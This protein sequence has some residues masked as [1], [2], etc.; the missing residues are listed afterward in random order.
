MRKFLTVIATLLLTV[1]V[2]FADGPFRNHRYDA[3]KVL[4]VTSDDIVFIGNSI[5]NM[6]EWWEAFGN[7]NVKN[8]GVS[9]AVTQEALD[10]IEAI[11]AGNPKKAFIMLGTNDLGTAG[12]NNAEHV[13]RNV[14]LI[15]ERFR[16][17]S[18]DTKLYIQS[19]LPSGLRDMTLQQ[20]T[21]EALSALCDGTDVIYIDLWTML[22]GIE[23][24]ANGLSYDKLHLTA[25]A[26]KIWCDAIAPYVMDNDE[27]A[28]VYPAD[29]ANLQQN[30]G[31]STSY[32]MRA[33]VFSLLPV[34]NDD[35]LMVGD[36]MIHGGEWHELLQ[37]AK[38]KSRGT[39]WGYPGPSLAQMLSY[40]PT[41]LHDDD[42]PAQVFLYT[43]V[44]DVNGSTE[45]ATV[46]ENYK[47]IV[48][49]ILE[50]SPNTK[51]TMMSLQPTSTASTNTGRVKPFNDML[52]EYA[53]EDNAD[54]IEY[55]D[56]YSDF[57]TSENVANTD[58]FTGNYLYGKGYVKVAQSVAAAINEDG[59]VA[60]TDEKAD[61]LYTRF[62]NRTALGQAITTAA[63][64]PEGDGVGQ[65]TTA[66]L[67]DVK[68]AISS[69]YSALKSSTTA[70]ES[71]TD[72]IS[73]LTTAT[74]N[75]RP[76]I[77]L[78][79]ASTTDATVWYQLYTPNRN[80]KYLS[81]NGVGEGVTGEDANNY[82]ATMWKFVERDDNTF[83]IINRK[84]GSYLNPVANYD[85]QVYTSEAKPDAGWTFEY[86]NTPGLFIVHCGTVQLNQTTK[87]GTPVYNW[88]AGQTGTDRSDTGCQ[89]KIL[90]V[91]GEPDVEPVVPTDE[92]FNNVVKKI[93]NLTEGWYQMRVLSG[94]ATVEGYVSAGTNNVLNANEEYRQSASNYYSLKLAAYDSSKPATAWVYIKPIGSKYLVKSINGHAVLENCTSSRDI[95]QGYTT[96]SMS[97]GGF[98]SVDKWCYW[99][100]G[101][102]EAPFIGKV[103]SS[104]NK[105]AFSRVAD[106]ELSAY[107]IYTVVIDGIE[108]AT[109]IGNDPS[110][111]YT[112]SAA[113]GGISKVYNNGNFFFPA[114]TVPV[115][116]DFTI[117]EGNYELTV[118]AT[119]KTLTV[120]T[121]VA[122]DP[123]Y[124]TLNFAFTRGT[125][126][127]NSVVTVTDANGLTLTDVTATIVAT[128]A[129]N[130]WLSGTD[131]DSNTDILCVNT[132]SNAATSAY[133]ITYTLSISGLPEGWS[134]DKALFNHRA[135][136]KKGVFQS[137]SETTTDFHCNF[138]LQSG[139]TGDALESFASLTD[140]SIMVPSPNV[141]TL[142][143]ANESAAESV[144]GNL[145]VKLT[146]YMGTTNN[147]CFYGLNGITLQMPEEEEVEVPVDYIVSPSTGV[148]YRDG[149]TTGQ[150]W[151]NKWV[152]TTSTE[153]PVELTLVSNAN[154]MT[155]SNG[156]LQLAGG[157]SGTATY[158]L[159]VPTGYMITGY[160]FD[161]VRAGSSDMTITIGDNNY[162]ATTT[163]ANV[164]ITNL[165]T[166]ST[167]FV[168]SGGNNTVN[169]SNF[170]V[171]IEKDNYGTEIALGVTAAGIGATDVSLLRFN[172]TIDASIVPVTFDGIKGSLGV[173]GAVKKLYVYSVADGFEYY[174]GK[175]DATLL[176]EATPNA[177]GTYSIIFDEA[178]ELAEGASLKYWLVADINDNV[179]EGTVIDASI[180]A[181][182]VSGEELAEVAG[183][184]QYSTT[185][186][187]TASTV[188]YSNA[189][190]SRYYRIPAITTAMNGWLVAVTDKR[191][192]SA[193]D[194]PNNIDVV[195]RVSKDNGATWGEPVTI[196]GT[197]QLG[198][199]YGHGDPAVVT[200]RIT[201]DIIVLV[202]SKV[203]FFSGTPDNPPLLK[204]IVSHDN[205]ETWD[206][207]VD[208]TGQI[209]GS[210]CADE[211]RK[212]WYSM[213][214][215]S[216][217]FLQT[218]NG[219]LMCVAPV[220]TTESTT[221][222]TF[223]AHI[224]RSADHGKTWTCKAIPALTDAD[225]SKIVELNDG[226][227]LVKSRHAGK[228]Y[229]AISSDDGETWTA[230]ST[231]SELDEPGCNGDLIRLTSE[232]KEEG[233]NRLL[234]SIPN[235]SSRKN[236]TVFLSTDEAQ[237][238]PTKKTICPRG[239]AYSSMTVLEDGTIGIYYEEDALEGGYQM[240]FT[241]FSLDWL[242]NNADNIDTDK[243]TAAR[244]KEAQALAKKLPEISATVNS[245]AENVELG[246]YASEYKITDEIVNA[247]KSAETS[248]D[249]QTV[250][251]ALTDYMT[252]YTSSLV[253][254]K[255][256]KVY[257]IKSV[258]DT[259]VEG[260][261][262]YYIANG[263][264]TTV[265][266]NSAT[267][268]VCQQSADDNFRTFVSVVGDKYL[269]WQ[270]LST[271]AAHSY[272]ID[273]GTQTGRF[274]L[275]SAGNSRYL[276]LTNEYHGSTAGTAT[277]AY[278]K[279]TAILQKGTWSSEFIFEE[280]S[281]DEF[282]G[283]AASVNEGKSGNYGTLNLPYAVYM[284]EGVVAK[285]LAYDAADATNELVET[286]LLLENDILPA[287]TPVL[288]KSDV[289][290][291]YSFVPAPA[292][293]TSALATGMRGTLGATAVT[294]ENVYILAYAGAVGSELCFYLLDSSDNVVNA[295]KAY[296]VLNG[297][298]AST[299]LRLGGDNTTGIDAVDGDG[300]A[301]NVIYDLTGR[302]L[303]AVTSPG[304]YII[305][306][307]KVMINW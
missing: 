167:S 284:P 117:P 150:T 212:E 184:P 285:S 73:A 188:E 79:I 204:M 232:A 209:Y 250:Q 68:S 300:S 213:F 252:T 305:N 226:R 122:S 257:R 115:A 90:E 297:A 294:E 38:V 258:I 123:D 36:E 72:E 243:F 289:A 178:V 221:H 149:S 281:A 11:A 62:T 270:A 216:G 236:I 173:A 200:D 14:S 187:L 288:L 112:G 93:V 279:S 287:N 251:N 181:F 48:N 18:P 283:F 78:P 140:A 25:A 272:R 203:G 99:E 261:A 259:S 307:R 295:N 220:R 17:T 241:R 292:L 100:N 267:L 304:I 46:L 106:T 182:T 219:T 23:T 263:A 160:S 104:S 82:A 131:I 7:H 145:V 276:A 249:L 64:L 132:N 66:N 37:S 55:L 8:R 127:S 183:N 45:L 116:S 10:N 102:D 101:D 164:N 198:G 51:V 225:E 157:S 303:D 247:L 69:G 231:W 92:N 80:S 227:L 170:K 290:E 299:S 108:N 3:F 223:E 195:A 268:W 253:L 135:L 75:V 154:N 273:P 246:G 152:F 134:F 245:A 54:L 235:A 137:T 77:N 63:L 163:S 201:G 109:E 103:S 153:Q 296:F 86:S 58:Y 206:A 255:D 238:W 56:I 155:N 49:K 35:I 211:T 76:S 185:V 87:S 158:T 141:K 114:G 274:G 237:T 71:F 262:D 165:S 147:G 161:C 171:V 168:L 291:V 278:N 113:I 96:V 301:E 30:G 120:A 52:A 302:K 16:Q 61:E 275:W 190:G 144:D 148:L 44:S 65:Y 179:T 244:L 57:V 9:G 265:A 126:L 180:T 105:Y 242:T 28:S 13:K 27:A 15:I 5:T 1:S 239:S 74:T 146:L 2:A 306:G 50:L 205:G 41:I 174:A 20:E 256:G 40:I 194:L 124:T 130:A 84:D 12:I 172:F 142:T 136:N 60:I 228:V 4:P 189:N 110:V 133:P 169:F 218:S 192:S 156:T 19:I 125:S 162:T 88:S 70:T 166:N 254:P 233:V 286:E 22:S 197:A 271:S 191:Y 26:Y 6:H 229:Y 89:Y 293:G 177:D 98:A 269:G 215:S 214:F 21:N 151:N 210:T 107:D 176:G 139:V 240:R 83:D 43:G 217:A 53:A 202:T 280:V 128:A 59:I 222:S 94:D 266:D 119:A 186:F 47:A 24:N 248:S 121:I 67:A 118:D 199:D 196:A 208:I 230:R 277:V 34:A 260:Y 97:Y 91:T 175:A 234:L 33:T 29:A 81:T 95:T 193:G 111:T 138:E 39:A 282:E 159:S 42:T 32:G 143:F 224:I 264:F 129:S 85:T 31:L 207:P 298:N